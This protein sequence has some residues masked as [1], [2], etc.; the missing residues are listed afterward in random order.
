MGFQ[1]DNLENL[2]N[3]SAA[4]LTKVTH[5]LLPNGTNGNTG[6]SGN[7]DFMGQKY[8]GQ[9]RRQGTD[10]TTEAGYVTPYQM[11]SSKTSERKKIKDPCMG[12]INLRS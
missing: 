6:G 10:T 4:T 9:T 8:W 7:A 1:K 5:C 2:K 11:S 12:F 3:A